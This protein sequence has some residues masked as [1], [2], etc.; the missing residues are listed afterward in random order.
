M[1]ATTTTGRASED[2]TA[3]APGW[4]ALREHVEATK[5]ELT[6]R[7]LAGLALRPGQHVVELGCGTGELARR[8]AGQVSPGGSVVASDIAPGMAALARETLA[9]VEG[10]TVVVADAAD[11]GLPGG[12]ADA[13]VFR[14]GPMLMPDP[15]AV[16][17]EARRLL[18]RGGVF[19]AAVWAGLQDN[20]WLSSVGMA[21]MMAGLVQGG[22]PTGPGGIFSLADPDAFAQVARDGG[23]TEV[24][25]E[26][27]P[28]QFRVRDHDHHLQVVSSLAGPLAGA[29][30]AATDEQRTAVRE[31]VTQLTEQYVGPDGLVLPAKALLLL[32]R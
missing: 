25:V 10:V 23:F 30:H 20:P 14:M 4:D 26:A 21:A 28:L 15:V 5:E 2:W 1:T 11:T 27:V 3:V 18:T 29:L 8:L 6:E 7:L 16:A 9:A 24:H 12:S 22:P 17:A 32:A 13:V 31:T 19:A